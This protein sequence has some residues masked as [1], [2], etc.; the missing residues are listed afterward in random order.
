VVDSESSD[1]TAEIAKSYGAK[2]I[3]HPFE[4]YSAQR[5]WALDNLP[6]S[7]DWILVLDA[8]ERIPA[9]L[10][11]EIRRVISDS[12]NDNVGFYLNRR[13]FFM[14]RWLKHGG[15]Y[16]SWILR[17][18]R[19][20]A[21]RFDNRLV[22]EHV[23]LTGKHGNLQN[24]FDHKDQRPLSEWIGR[25]DRYADLEAEEYLHENSGLADP[26]AIPA[27]F[28]GS[29]PERKRWTKLYVWNKLPLLIRPFLFFIR[30]YVLR[31]G[32]LDGKPGFIYH[33]LWSFWYPF[34]VSAK[35]VEKIKNQEQAKCGVV[36]NSD[37]PAATREG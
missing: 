19:R 32:F 8:D 1:R 11:E 35:V 31:G 28:W 14:G 13:F 37:V 12:Q 7:H 9:Q 26:H 30:S 34:L 15:L 23:V 33:V 10:S 4:G 36:V 25:H 20:E 27:C 5:N 24:P 18:F 29:Q 17:L 22:N 3:V 16:P 6:F 2:V 21:G